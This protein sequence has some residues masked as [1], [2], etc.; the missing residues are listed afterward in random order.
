M[1]SMLDMNTC[2]RKF[3]HNRFAEFNKTQHISSIIIVVDAH[4][5][6]FKIESLTA[7]WWQF[8][9]WYGIYVWQ[10]STLLMCTYI[11]R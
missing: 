11:S 7:T 5:L 4:Y 6:I 10:M 3:L 2:A 8:E 9:F 1:H